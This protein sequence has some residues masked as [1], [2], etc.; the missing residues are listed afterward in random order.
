MAQAR[1]PFVESVARR[2]EAERIG[3]H[4]RLGSGLLVDLGEGTLLRVGE[5]WLEVTVSTPHG[6][7]AGEDFT[8]E[9][10]REEAILTAFRAGLGARLTERGWKEIDIRTTESTISDTDHVPATVTEIVSRLETG[11]AD[12]AAEEIAWIVSRI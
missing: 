10:A 9:D 7:A 6:A 11:D 1:S 4:R 5:A 8:A 12:R 3:D 2:L